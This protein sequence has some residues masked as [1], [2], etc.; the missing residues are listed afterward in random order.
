MHTL[1]TL[2]AAFRNTQQNCFSHMFLTFCRHSELVNISEFTLLTLYYKDH[3]EAMGLSTLT[4][5]CKQS[6]LLYFCHLLTMTRVTKTEDYLIKPF[7]VVRLVK[8]LN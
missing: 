3:Q 2:K 5:A 7:V 6:S 1:V 8:W 4:R